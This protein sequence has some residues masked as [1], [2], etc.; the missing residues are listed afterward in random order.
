M[1]EGEHARIHVPFDL[2]YGSSPQGIQVPCKT[3]TFLLKHFRTLAN[4]FQ[5]MQGGAWFIPGN[6]NLFFDTEILH[7]VGRAKPEPADL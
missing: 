1:R 4:S 6:S 5:S 2:G 3:R 7:R